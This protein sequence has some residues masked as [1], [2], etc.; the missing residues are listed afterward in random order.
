[1]KINFADENLIRMSPPTKSPVL[2]IDQHFSGAKIPS[3]YLMN[4]NFVE[5]SKMYAEEFT[6]DRSSLH[7]KTDGKNWPN[8]ISKF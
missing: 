6:W 5:A 4:Q 7:H 3:F 2:P 8:S 1:M